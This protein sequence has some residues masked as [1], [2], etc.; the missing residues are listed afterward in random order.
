MSRAV[1]PTFEK[2]SSYLFGHVKLLPIDASREEID[3]CQY[4]RLRDV[5]RLAN[6]TKF[7]R[8]KFQELGVDVD[9]VERVSDLKLRVT[10]KDVENYQHLM[11]RKGCYLTFK[12]Y[13]SG[14]TGEPLGISHSFSQF[15]PMLPFQE[16]F[17]QFMGLS[18]KDTVLLVF[19]CE[20]SSF[21][22]SVIGFS[23]AGFHTEVADYFDLKDQIQ[24]LRSATVLFGHG[25]KILQLI[26]KAGRKA[27]EN[28]RVVAFI[29]EPIVPA[30]KQFIESETGAKVHGVY[31]SIEA[32]CPIAITCHEGK[33]HLMPEL[34]LMEIDEKEDVLST[35][36][37]KN[38]ATILL[39]YEMGDKASWENCNCRCSF[40]A[41]RLDAK[42]RHLT[43]QRIE[44]AIC[45]SEAFKE[46]KISPYFDYETQV[47][48]CKRVFKIFLEKQDETEDASVAEEIKNILLYGHKNG[49][50]GPLYALP[51]VE[52]NVMEIEVRLVKAINRIKN[53]RFW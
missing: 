52:G 25:T 16:R 50:L 41:F 11:R 9:R 6:R 5:V 2:I 1:L 7:Y 37:D 42:F 26:Q 27:V 24:K 36:L 40:P 32:M 33:Y 38:R 4:E 39:R 8:K 3:L 17:Y 49:A 23:L 46:G 19:P 13:T 53:P 20:A 21:M 45:S 15:L 12:A 35:F 18:K 34:V 28:L 48:G 10:R 30:G 51:I 29:S 44:E 14:S 47:V 43:S 22:L 31:G